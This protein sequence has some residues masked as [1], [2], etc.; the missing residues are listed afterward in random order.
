MTDYQLLEVTADASPEEIRKAFRKRALK[1][2]PDQGGDAEEFKKL[3]GAFERTLEAALQKSP[4]PLWPEARTGF[5]GYDPFD[6]P[7]YGTYKFFEPENS[8]IGAFERGIIAQDCPHCRGLAIKT[9][10]TRPNDFMSVEDRF[11]ICQRVK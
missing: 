3:K 10:A 5:G 1:L 9:R 11:C 6:D 7:N 4:L 8:E 2:H